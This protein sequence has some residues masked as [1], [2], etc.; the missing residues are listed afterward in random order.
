MGA[1]YFN[2]F[3]VRLL[4]WQKLALKNSLDN[5]LITLQ[6]KDF[7]CHITAICLKFLLTSEIYILFLFYLNFSKEMAQSLNGQLSTRVISFAF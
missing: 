5:R 3:L 1:F 2:N 7:S 6:Q 4:Q